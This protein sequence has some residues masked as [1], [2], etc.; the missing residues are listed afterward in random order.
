M[1]NEMMGMAV[2]HPYYCS[3]S[4]YY[5]NKPSM[6][7][8]TMT[9]FLDEFEGTDIDMNLVFRWDIKPREIVT[10]KQ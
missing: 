4:N 8:E 6:T 9:E 3:E 2:E 10:G 5:S 7:W 1:S